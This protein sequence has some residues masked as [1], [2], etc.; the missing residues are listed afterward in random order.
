VCVFE[1]PE[2]WVLRS[3]YF[4]L[5]AGTSVNWWKAVSPS[6]QLALV[7]WQYSSGGLRIVPCIAQLT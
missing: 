3:K 5:N 4:A 7:N 6:R 1:L 2:R